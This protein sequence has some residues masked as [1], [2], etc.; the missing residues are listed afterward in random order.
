M[1]ERSMLTITHN[2]FISNKH[3]NNKINIIKL[4]HNSIQYAIVVNMVCNN[5]Y[6]YTHSNIINILK[7]LLKESLKR[8]KT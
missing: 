3:N 4:S 8:E 2:K 7:R 1:N 5:V 6:I